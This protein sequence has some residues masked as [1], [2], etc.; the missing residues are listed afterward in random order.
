[1]WNICENALLNFEP[2]VFKS[3]DDTDLECNLQV[4]QINIK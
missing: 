1:M 2:K 3:T 4:K